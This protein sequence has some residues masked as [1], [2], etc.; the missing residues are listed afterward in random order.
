MAKKLDPKDVEIFLLENLDFFKEREALVTELKFGHPET[1]GASS[2]LER[3]I[4]KLRNEQK[5]LMELLTNFMETATLN[6]D[7]FNKSKDLTLSLI[8]I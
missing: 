4:H 6:E 1:R 5:E 2:L 7:L 3:Q 8:H